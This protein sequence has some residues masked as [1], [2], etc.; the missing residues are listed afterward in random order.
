M[1]YYGKL[2]EKNTAIKL[3]KEGLSYTEIRKTVKV[4]KSTLS[5]WCRHIALDSQ[6]EKRLNK[7]K[8]DGAMRGRLVGAKKQQLKRIEM[9]NDLI[10]SGKERV[11]KLTQNEFF[12][13]GASLYLGDGM[14]GDKSVGFTNA[15][16][17]L[18]RF[19][20]RWF[21]EFCDI[22]ESSYRGA[23]WLHPGLDEKKAKLFWSKISGIPLEKFHKTY[24]TVDKSNSRKIR[25]NIHK[26]GIFS[27]RASVAKIQREIK[28]YME[29]IM[30]NA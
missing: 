16:P 17:R 8:M 30:E 28:G 24:I 20:M 22:P 14:K 1:G 27:V 5:I 26:Y 18:I 2:Q 7:V 23:I 25:K 3:R 19:M 15:N 29:G 9:T 21:R 12:I 13:A 11:G 10:K 6:Q 4:S